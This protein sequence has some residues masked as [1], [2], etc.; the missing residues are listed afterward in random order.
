MNCVLCG[1]TPCKP[2][3]YLGVNGDVKMCE[4]CFDIIR[5][6]MMEE[7][8]DR[9]HTQFHMPLIVEAFERGVQC[10]QAMAQKQEKQT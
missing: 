7:F 9:L 1:L 10:G 3:V 8:A 6:A 5:Q 4:T 2:R